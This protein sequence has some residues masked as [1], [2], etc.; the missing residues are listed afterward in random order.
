MYKYTDKNRIHLHELDGRPLIGTS[1]VV[2]V[3]A[4][5]LVWWAAELSAVECLEVGEK[6]PTI[7]EEYLLACSSPDK[8]TAIDTLQKK[9]PL[10]KK[11][12]FAHFASKNDKAEKGTDMHAELEKYIKACLERGGG[13]EQIE[14]EH[15]AVKIFSEW[16]I[17]NVDKFLWSEIHCYSEN[18]WVGGIIDA[19]FI[20]KQGKVGIIDF[21][22]AKEAY[23][24]YF[25][26]IAG[27]D[28]QINENG[29]YDADGKK[30]LELPKPIDYYLVFPFGAE[31]PEAIT[32]YDIEPLKEGFKS[33]LVLYK[34]TENK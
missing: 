23:I 21:K 20:D 32:N 5:N 12:R 28:L 29:G 24:S 10:F 17:V 9:Y 11:A 27:Y 6:I 2:G 13:P 33:A 7:R 22:S 31:K 1:K 30:I 34:L 15:K 8:K 19:G 18:M 25:I 14:T 16:A 4:K 3:I 26:Q